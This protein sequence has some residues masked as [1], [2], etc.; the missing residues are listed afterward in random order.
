MTTPADR[1]PPQDE[2][3]RAVFERAD[4]TALDAIA[5]ECAVS[6]RAS[7]NQ[8]VS[9]PMIYG[10]LWERLHAYSLTTGEYVPA[11]V[12]RLARGA[13]ARADSAQHDPEKLATI[14]PRTLERDRLGLV[15]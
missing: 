9:F 7:T 11:V 6:L 14:I 3:M 1:V 2:Q 8:P 10:A 15:P 12:A 5:L 13:A 4:A